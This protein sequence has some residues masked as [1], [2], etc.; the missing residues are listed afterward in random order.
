MGRFKTESDARQVGTGGEYVGPRYPWLQPAICQAAQRGLL[1]WARASSS[2]RSAA[3]EPRVQRQYSRLVRCSLAIVISRRGAG[4]PRRLIPHSVAPLLV[5]RSVEE[6]RGGVEYVPARYLPSLVPSSSAAAALTAVHGSGPSSLFLALAPAAAPTSSNPTHPILPI[7]S[8]AY[9]NANLLRR[10]ALRFLPPTPTEIPAPSLPPPRALRRRSAKHTTHAQHG[11]RA[12]VLVL[13]CYPRTTKG[14]VDIKPNSSELSYLLY[15]ATSRRSKIQKIG[16]F[17]EKKTAS[18]VWRLRF[19]NVQ[20]T[21]QILAALIEKLHKD[22]VLIAPYVLKVLDTVLRSDDITMIESSLPTFEAFCEFHDGTILSADHNYLRQYEDIVQLYTQ[23]ASPSHSPGKAPVSNPVQMRWRIAGLEAIRSISNADAL[24]S[25]TGRQMDVIVP[26]I[27]ENLWSDSDEFLDVLQNRASGGERGDPEKM[28]KRRTSIA[29]VDTA[30]DTNPVAMTGTAGD[31]D[32]LAEE[33]IGVLAMECLKSIFVVPNRSQIH[34]A[35]LSLLRFILDRVSQGDSVVTLN[36]NR[37]RDSGWAISIYNIVARWAPVQ[38]RYVILVAA[39]DTLLR[40]PIQDDTIMQQVALTAM[41]SSLLRSDVNLIG[42][43]VMDV[44]LGLIKQMRKL[45][46]LRTPTSHSDDGVNPTDAE[47][48]KRLQT[49]HLLG[50]LELCIG[51]LATH[52]YYADQISDMIGAVIIR[53]KPTRSSSTNSSPGEKT[54]ATND[55]G[56]AASTVELTESQSQLDH[57]FSLNAG[58]ASALNV[59]KAILL[60]ANPQKKLTG[61]RA[62]SRNPVPLHVWEG[63]HWLLR[64]PDGHVRKAYM[65]ALITWLDR[66]TTVADEKARD[67]T[68]PRS[69][70]SV[71]VNRDLAHSTTARRVVSSASNRDRSSRTAPSQ[72]LPLLH[73]VIYDNALQFVEYENDLV[74]LH[75]LL[76]KLVFKLGVNSI[77]HGLP[78]VY[79]LQEEIQDIDTPIHKV[80]VAALCHG[81]FWALTEKFDFE[82]SVVG[83]AIQNEVVRRR[84]KGFWVEGIHI[85]P[86]TTDLVGNPGEVRPQPHWDVNALE[87]EELLP[88]DD[89]SS[90]VECIAASYEDSFRTPPGSP[91]ASP[92]RGFSGP[93][94]GSTINTASNAEPESDLPPVFR[95]QMLTDWSRDAAVAMLA[96][97]GKS[98]SLTGSKTGTSLTNRGH[99]T[100]NT[101]G[102]NGNGNGLISPYGSQFNLMPNSQ[103]NQERERE[104]TAKP[105]KSSMRSAISPS[106]SM[107]SR[108]AVASVDQLKQVL[109]GAP[110]PKTAGLAGGDDDS[111]ES[112][113]SYD[114]SPSEISFNPPTQADQA[115][116]PTSGVK[117]STS[118]RRGPLSAHPPHEGPPDLHDEV[119]VDDEA[120]PPVPPLPN[121][122]LLG[123]KKSPIHTTEVSFQDQALKSGRRSLRSRGGD[124]ARPR[125]GSQQDSGKGM[126]LQDLLRGIDSRSGEGSLSNVMRPPY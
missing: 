53:L 74:M 67:E 96:S 36:D 91:T 97:V 112:M 30:G 61:N 122:A 29:T 79:R 70:S 113:V 56:P 71:K 52:V 68:L 102:V 123:G 82:A 124:G 59:V 103:A 85:P 93:I 109:S 3:Q 106:L 42:L 31:V 40:I 11:N 83:R 88:F 62:L 27:L 10:I 99:L 48:G 77:R 63:T 34:G 28:V 107:S 44:L 9:I 120:V 87:R 95:E 89:R 73:L 78:M 119:E 16:A 84:S 58:R 57:Y 115:I 121:V 75:I 19:G 90:L 32:K 54:G 25:I 41:M 43:S 108:G 12:G 15:Y 111:G 98:E 66:E 110:P 38:D 104:G 49:K 23:L 33:D 118:V 39:L 94:L 126:D 20:V 22:V 47:Q 7:H 60:V 35:T 76:T 37:E 86:P 80:R 100:V 50:Q 51:D 14:A 26:R 55:T 45:F 125:S 116:S 24:S 18:D 64:D 81:Y 8:H 69:R 101:T 72:F 114:Y 4:V 17:L 13:K 5:S 6:C 92:S 65:D 1:K 117:R 2:P 46:K 105:R 21:L